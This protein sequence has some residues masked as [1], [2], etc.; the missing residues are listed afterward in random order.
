MNDARRQNNL[1]ITICMSQNSLGNSYEWLILGL[2]WVMKGN[3]EKKLISIAADFVWD[4]L[5]WA[6]I[7]LL[8]LQRGSVINTR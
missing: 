3:E 7:A 1:I 2:D 5:V 8:R 4:V 6:V